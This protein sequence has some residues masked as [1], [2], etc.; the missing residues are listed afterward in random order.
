MSQSRE[1]IEA[2]LAAFASGQPDQVAANVTEDFENV[3]L[4]ALGLGC[5]GRAAYAERL[6]GFLSDFQEIRYELEG[7]MDAGSAAAIMYTMRFRQDGAPF[8]VSGMMWFEL[9]DG[10]IARRTDCWDG[11][12]YLQQ[13]SLNASEIFD[14]V[15]GT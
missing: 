11:V 1:R 9:K 10:L 15:Q 12:A 2:Y 14:L 4:G 8:T 3:H 7:F 13:T 5:S 6:K